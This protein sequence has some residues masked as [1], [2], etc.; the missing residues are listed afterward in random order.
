M[1]RPR[2]SGLHPTRRHRLA[3]TRSS[4][5]RPAPEPA[6]TSCSATLPTGAP[7]VEHARELIPAASRVGLGYL[8]HIVAAT[9][10]IV[11]ERI[12]T[13][14]APGDAAT[15][16]APEGTPD[17]LANGRPAP[18]PPNAI[19]CIRSGSRRWGCP[20]AAGSRPG[21]QLVVQRQHRAGRQVARRHIGEIPSR[22]RLISGDE[23]VRPRGSTEVVG[24]ESHTAYAPDSVGPSRGTPPAAW[25]ATSTTDRFGPGTWPLGPTRTSA[26]AAGPPERWPV[27]SSR[28]WWACWLS[29]LP[30]I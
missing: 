21:E 24:V 29:A 5:A 30:A 10:P 19:R 8:Q 3:A 27:A 6:V 15:L 14:A 18:A 17:L 25:F 22:A 9:A 16:R 12:T 13:R 20:T 7:Y 1:T 23:Q 26:H 2:I 28:S 4:L 11:G